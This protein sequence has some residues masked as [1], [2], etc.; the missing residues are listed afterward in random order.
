MEVEDI[1][2]DNAVQNI[3]GEKVFLENLTVNAQ[4]LIGRINLLNFQKLYQNSVLSGR[5]EKIYANIVSVFKT[6]D[7]SGIIHKVAI[8]AAFVLYKNV[9]LL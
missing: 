7:K 4:L 3:S 1:V 5:N 9:F 8:P 2:T 6:L